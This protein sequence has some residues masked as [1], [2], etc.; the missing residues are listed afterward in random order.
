MVGLSGYILGVYF[1]L[2]LC[3]IVYGAMQFVMSCSS[4][5]LRFGLP[6]FIVGSVVMSLATTSPELFVSYLS[7]SQGYVWLGVGNVFGSYIANIGLVL[8]V[9]GLL[10]PVMV[11]QSILSK[12]IPYCILGVC[13]LIV[14]SLKNTLFWVDACLLL[15]LLGGWFVAVVYN[16]ESSESVISTQHTTLEML[17]RLILGVGLL[18]MGSWLLIE[19]SQALAIQFGVSSYV[20]G[21]TLVAISTSLPELS[22]A[23]V[24]VYLKEYDLL[25]G[26]IVG[27]N[28]LLLLLVLPV[29]ILAAGRPIVLSMV[30]PEYFF[31]ALL[32]MLLWLFVTHFDDQAR[33][34]RQ[35]AAGLLL[36]FLAYQFFVLLYV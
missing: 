5:S 3:I 33:I 25:M 19:S 9:A 12:Q 10:R 35:E 4:I 29:T 23:L 7:A 30:W 17:L 20:I 11:S 31:M 21:L 24:S 18:Y 15:L 34:G 8:G 14:C 27:A 1:L 6:K 28:I 22:S 16:Q 32:T 13:V 2:G 26:N 36:S